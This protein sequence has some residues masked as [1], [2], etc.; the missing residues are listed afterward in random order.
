MRNLGEAFAGFQEI[1]RQILQLLAHGNID[2]VFIGVH[3]PPQS[4]TGR[5]IETR[6]FTKIVLPFPEL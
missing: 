4:I 3:G 6:A 2:F 5:C 1:A